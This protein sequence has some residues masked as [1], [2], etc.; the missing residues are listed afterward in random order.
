MHLEQILKNLENEFGTLYQKTGLKS[1]AVKARNDINTDLHHLKLQDL[2]KSLCTQ[3][4]FEH[5]LDKYPGN[6][7][8]NKRCE[9]CGLWV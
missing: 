5:L 1:K 6:N 8:K 2:S 3:R 7:R 4:I 9:L